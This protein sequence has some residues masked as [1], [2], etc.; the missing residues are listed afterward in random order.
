[1]LRTGGFVSV[2]L[3]A[4][5]WLALISPGVVIGLAI[6][7]LT[8]TSFVLWG[9]VGG[10]LIWAAAVGIDRLRHRHRKCRV[11]FSPAL[12]ETQLEQVEEAARYAGIKFEHQIDDPLLFAEADRPDDP[13]A[14]PEPSSVF[15]LKNQYRK[16][17]RTIV[18]N[19]VDGER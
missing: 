9:I 5:G 1:M 2:E 3:N 4:A 6:A 10:V 7:R 19:K 17:L 8:G 15:T 16:R 12:T 18:N 14:I 13:Q 11:L